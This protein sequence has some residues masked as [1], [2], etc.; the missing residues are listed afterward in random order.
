MSSFFQIF[1][2]PSLVFTRVKERGSWAAPMVLSALIT[3]IAAYLITHAIGMEN[4]TR[5]FFDEHPTYAQRMS[6]AQLQQ[7]IE[8][9]ASPARAAMSA[10]SVGIITVITTLVIALVVMI[11]LSVMDRKPDFTRMLGTVA[12]SGFPFTVV[13][14]LMAGLILMLTADKAELDPA[15]L[16]ATNIGAFLDKNSTGKFVYSLARSFD[17]LAI[18]QI[19]LLSFGI[20]RVVGVS[21]S[22][23][24][25]LVFVLWLLWVL[26]R[27]GVAA[28]FGF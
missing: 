15:T 9:S 2:A 27:A 23:A 4:L 8:Q 17:L 14:L 24:F 3:M 6:P 21:F 19:L 11:L 1:Y 16:V 12:W 28:A 25:M 10:G 13:G 5:R 18:G 20:S 22:R 7:A 26:L